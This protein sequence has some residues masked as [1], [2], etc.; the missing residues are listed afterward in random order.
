MNAFLEENLTIIKQKDPSL[1]LRISKTEP[2]DLIGFTT[3]RSGLTLP[4][5]RRDGRERT[6]HSRFDPLREGEKLRPSQ[7]DKK[8]RVFLGLGGAYHITPNV[9]KGQILI[10]EADLGHL[11]ALLRA[12]DYKDL[13][14]SPGVSLLAA[15]QSGELSGY[16]KGRYMPLLDGPLEVIPLR[17]EVSLFPKVFNKYTEEVDLALG[18]IAADCST[19]KQLGRL[20]QRQI[21]G[22]AMGVVRSPL[23]FSPQQKDTPAM[24]AAAGPSLEKHKEEMAGR[25][26]ETPLVA[27]DT[28]FPALLE[29]GITPDVVVVLDPRFIGYLHFMK[30]VPPRCTLWAE[31]GCSLPKHIKNVHWF[32]TPHPLQDYLFGD[33]KGGVKCLSAGGNVTQAAV[34]LLLRSGRRDITLFGADF[35]YPQGKSY[36]RGTYFYPWF[37]LQSYRPNPLENHMTS[38]V[39]DQ[40]NLYR[41]N[42][43]SPSI[44]GTPRLKQYGDQFD[45]F[46]RDLGISQQSDDGGRRRLRGSIEPQGEIRPP[47]RNLPWEA[48]YQALNTPLEE[49]PGPVLSTLIPTAYSFLKGHEG[50]KALKAAADYTKSLIRTRVP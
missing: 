33:S 43:T 34:E 46:C 16:L 45:R 30:K 20:W 11:K 6:Y 37:D 29:W 31:A 42:D 10:V 14:S 5:T 41:V 48:Y 36:A 49:L 32:L 12:I 39:L 9:N 23:L 17:E 40:K 44:Y 24:V 4:F 7:S 19:Q 35:A 13:L 50:E 18:E 1:A 22:N 28:A 26:S 8:F 21:I 47:G 25:T 27:V 2:S 15:P 3:S 38:F